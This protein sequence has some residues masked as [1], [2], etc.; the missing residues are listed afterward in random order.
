[1]RETLIGLFDREFIES[2]ED[3]GIEVIS[4]FRDIDRPDV[5][6]W[7]RGFPNMPARA[8]ALSA[9]YDGPVWARHR[10]TANATMCT[11]D[12][13]RLLRPVHPRS[14]IEVTR[15]RPGREAT[16]LPPG[17]VVVTIYTLAESAVDGFAEW[18]DVVVKPQLVLSGT[19]PIAMLETEPSENTFPRLPVREGERAFVWLA[20]FDDVAAHRHQ[21]AALAGNPKWSAEIKP[22]L[23][24]CLTVPPEVWRLTPTARSRTIL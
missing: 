15:E 14:G 19:R 22:E 7:L 10:D 18:F 16:A 24:R 6:T 11:W 8:A 20:R 13:V 23:T 21:I 3:V 17:I 2:Q 12:N 1:M 4:Q 9:F 5:F